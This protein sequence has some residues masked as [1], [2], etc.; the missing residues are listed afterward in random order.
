M[1]SRLTNAELNTDSQVQISIVINYFKLK[2]KPTSK[3]LILCFKQLEIFSFVT[4]VGEVNNECIGLK[5]LD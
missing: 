5:C 4:N 1:V 2:L 3:E